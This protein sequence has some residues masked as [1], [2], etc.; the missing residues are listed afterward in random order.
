MVEKGIHMKLLMEKTRPQIV[1]PE[2][3]VQIGLYEAIVLQQ[4][5]YWITET[6]SGV[7]YEGRRWIYNTLPDWHLQFPYLSLST[8]KRVFTHLRTAGLIEVRQLNKHL[9]DRTN[10]YS[11]NYQHKIL[12]TE[13]EEQNTSEEGSDNKTK[14]RAFDGAKQEQSK[15]SKSQSQNGSNRALLTEN[16]TKITTK[17]NLKRSCSDCSLSTR[18][19]PEIDIIRYFNKT[20][21]SHYR[22][23]QTTLSYVRARLVDGF[24]V[25]ELILITD[26]LTAKWLNDNKMQDY[27]RPKTLFHKNNCAE[28]LDKAKKWQLKGRP[29]YQNG[30][31]LK[32]GEIPI[33]I[34]CAERDNTFS[35]LFSSAWKPKTALQILAKKIALQRGLGRMHIH[36]AKALWKEIWYQSAQLIARSTHHN[37]IA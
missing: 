6:T 5:H 4:L 27:L 19:R 24:Q 7:E 25:D 10:F 3:A 28:Y 36:N 37:S 9:H 33:E 35:L 15:G 14:I 8:L 32:E 29:A 11:I 23:C 31:C 1:I 21:H 20:T 26:Y 16:T 2:L 34:D 22:E 30:R 18:E 17:S 12:K 13:D